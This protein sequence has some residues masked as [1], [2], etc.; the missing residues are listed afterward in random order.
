MPN[1]PVGTLSAVRRDKIAAQ[2]CSIAR[3][4]A[5]IAD[6]W[7]LLIVR[8]A[9]GGATRFADFLDGT[10]AQPSVVSDRLKRLLEGGIFERFEY[11]EHPP[12]QAYRLT[13]KGEDLLPLIA[14]MNKW[15]DTHL[16][17]GNGAPFVYR[18]TACGHDSDPTLVCG[19][20]GEPLTVGD[21]TRER[22]P[23]AAPD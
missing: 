17:G 19:S 14:A 4:A 23:G 6:A 1:N 9:L 18:H 12:R 7:T 8:E 13:P 11:S 21:V 3:T 22:G 5:V 2:Y 15:G 20:C 16:D 10:G